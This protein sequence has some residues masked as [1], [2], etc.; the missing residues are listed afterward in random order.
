MRPERD[1]FIAFSLAAADLLIAVDDGDRI[2]TVVGAARALLKAQPETLAGQAIPDMFEGAESAFIR[3]LAAHARE[4]GRIEPSVVMLGRDGHDKSPA[5]IGM[6]YL[7]GRNRLYISLTVLPRL[8]AQS[9]PPRDPETGLFHRAAFQQIAA[10]GLGPDDPGSG[11][12]MLRELRLIRM[13]GLPSLLERLPTR[14]AC[15]VMGEIGA[16]LR[17]EACNGGLA[18]QLDGDRFGLIAPVAPPAETAR[19]V[20]G[21]VAEVLHRA[22]A[23]PKAVATTSQTVALDR[24]MTPA[25]SAR[26]LAYAVCEFNKVEGLHHSALSQCL[27]TALEISEGKV[28]RVRALIAGRSFM[29]AYQ[30][31]VDIQSREVHHHEAL[32]RFEG[33]ASPFETVAPADRAGLAAD[34]D[35][36]VLDMVLANMRD[37]PDE[38]VAVTLS[39]LSLESDA[40]RGGVLRL[41]DAN[42]AYAR[43][44]IVAVT[45]SA[46]VEDMEPLARFLAELRHRGHDVCLDDFGAGANAYNYL[47][48]FDA[49]FVKVDGPFLKAALSQDRQRALVRSIALLCGDLKIRMIGGSIDSEAMIEGAAG[50]GVAFGQGLAFGKPRMRLTNTARPLKRAGEH[51][52]W[53]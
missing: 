39:G 43:Q 10:G 30:P 38:T 50:L 22:G 20:S 32:V 1:D 19:A 6:S 29:L 34:L 2:E 18:G 28:N 47:R 44:L 33:G 31:V 5:N 37:H 49:D 25:E 7:S 45:Q 4:H 52:T 21:Y 13:R 9:L 8:V 12:A 40:F 27:E 11:L 17:A 24:P 42:R 26:A 53:Q 46:G 14:K 35:A 51:E 48:R 16:Y 36:T 41:L 15:A 23:D 3:R